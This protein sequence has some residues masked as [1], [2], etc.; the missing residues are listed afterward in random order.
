MGQHREEIRRQPDRLELRLD[1]PPD[2]LGRRSGLE[3][4]LPVCHACPIVRIS[5]LCVLF[6]ASTHYLPGGSDEA[7]TDR[8]RSASRSRRYRRRG[9]WNARCHRLLGRHLQARRPG[10]DLADREREAR[11]RCSRCR[12]CGPAVGATHRVGC[13]APLP[14]ARSAGAA[15][16][17]RNGGGWKADGNGAPGSPARHVLGSARQRAVA[18]GSWLL[19]DRGRPDRRRRRPVRPCPHRRPRLREGARDLPGGCRL[20][21]RLRLRHARAEH[22]HGAVRHGGGRDRRQAGCSRAACASSR[23]SSAAGA[24]GCRGRC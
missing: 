3:E 19:R 9:G 5:R 11:L 17:R 20:L 21:D 6:T 7:V 2:E 8:C 10:A 15:R 1:D 13:E 12:A 24:R 23:C 16:L 18:R 14:A 22:R 4:E